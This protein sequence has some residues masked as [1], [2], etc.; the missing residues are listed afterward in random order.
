MCGRRSCSSANAGG[1]NRDFSYWFGAVGGF[2]IGPIAGGEPGA[3]IEFELLFDKLKPFEDPKVFAE[4]F[5]GVPFTMVLPMR[6]A[7]CAADS[8]AFASFAMS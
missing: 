4:G 6:E 7:P 2:P 5:V 3:A 8:A 1:A